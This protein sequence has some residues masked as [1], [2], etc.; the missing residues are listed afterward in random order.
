MYNRARYLAN[1]QLA[2]PLVGAAELNRV[3]GMETD[4]SS[5]QKPPEFKKMPLILSGGILLNF[6][7]GRFAKLLTNVY[8]IKKAL[9]AITLEFSDS[10]KI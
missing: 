1:R 9:V 8:L 10:L 7:L 2:E 3:F 5:T 6:R 4:V